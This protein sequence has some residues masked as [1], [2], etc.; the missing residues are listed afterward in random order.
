MAVRLLAMSDEA[1]LTARYR[2]TRRDFIAASEAAG[3][4]VISRVHPAKGAD[5]KPLFCDS[6]ALGPRDGVRALLLIEGNAGAVTGLLHR[7]T[8]LPDDARL[9]AVHALD[10]FVWAWGEPGAPA[11]W[12][13]KTLGSIATEDLSRVIKLAVLDFSGHA[14]EAALAAAL[15]K[16]AIVIRVPKPEHAEQAFAAAI[17]AL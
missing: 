3:G 7:I 10:P 16:A 9:V 1:N 4:D 12:P 2:Q 13:R 5:G 6:V 15:P 8:G 11:D 17:A 14:P